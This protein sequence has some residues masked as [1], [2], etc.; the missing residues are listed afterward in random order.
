MSKPSRLLNEDVQKEAELELLCKQ[1]GLCCHNKVPL[2]NGDYLIH[3]TNA[4][5]FLGPENR[6]R[7]YE[8]RFDV[9]PGC[10]SREEMISKDYVIPETCAYASIRKDYKPAKVVNE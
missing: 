9:N 8:K 4:C 10:L 1:C 7:I 6:C 5:Q 3:P 2:A